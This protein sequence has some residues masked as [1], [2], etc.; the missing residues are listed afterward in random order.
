MTLR[1]NSAAKTAN[2]KVML[3]SACQAV[4]ARIK[5]DA[6]GTWTGPKPELFGYPDDARSWRGVHHTEDGSFLAAVEAPNRCYICFYLHRNVSREDRKRLR[7]CRSYFQLWPERADENRYSIHFTLELMKDDSANAPAT[8][9][10]ESPGKF[11][12][13]PRSGKSHGRAFQFLL[14]EISQTC[15]TPAVDFTS[16]AI[17]SP[18]SVSRKSGNGLKRAR[19]DTSGALI[20][21]KRGQISTFDCLT[22]DSTYRTLCV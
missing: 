8:D 5:T 15:Q 14:I 9:I 13:F 2:H 3:C 1:R 17:R 7:N 21:G 20:N 22:L 6:R 18:R 11:K 12:L 10:I 16:P 19:S 4:L